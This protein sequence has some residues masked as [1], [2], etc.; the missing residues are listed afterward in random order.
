MT[1]W[2]ILTALVALMLPAAALAQAPAEAEPAPTVAEPAPAPA[3]PAAEPAPAPAE[4]PPAADAAPPKKKKVV[5]KKPAAKQGKPSAVKKWATK[6][7][8]NKKSKKNRRQRWPTRRP[9]EARNS[10]P[11]LV[12]TPYVPGERLV[13]EVKM[14]DSVAGEGILAVGS[15]VKRAG[16]TILPL[17]GF[18][19]SGEFLNRFYPVDNKMVVMLDEET[20]LPYKTDF[21]IREKGKVLDYHTVF[22]HR[23]KLVKSTRKKEGKTLTRNF[24][25]A[26]P[27]Y[28]ALGSVFGMRRMDL[29]PGMRMDYFAWTGLK[30]RWLSV[31]VVGE[32]R[33]WT[34]AGWFDALRLDVTSRT[35]GGFFRGA[36][37]LD[38]KPLTGKVWIATDANR[39]PIKLTT[40]TRIGEAEASLVRRYIEQDDKLSMK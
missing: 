21:Y 26:G 34:K 18:I 17:V 10:L 19:R 8:R 1:R 2:S 23:R 6:A 27:I 28:E 22:D 7:K 9:K 37:P 3:K 12:H 35:T 31:H 5:V 15:R 4:T 32:E 25:T 30:E 14:F 38:A 13:Y 33:V 39:T 11:E 20:F 24:T 16:R 40:P 29:K 36:A